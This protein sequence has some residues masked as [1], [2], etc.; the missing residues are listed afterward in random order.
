MGGLSFSVV[1]GG[2]VGTANSSKDDDDDADMY[3]LKFTYASKNRT[4][5]LKFHCLRSL[6]LIF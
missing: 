1:R 6:N 5:K 3:N 4:D 2:G